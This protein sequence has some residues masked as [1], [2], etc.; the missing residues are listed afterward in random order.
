MRL[1][2]ATIAALGLAACQPAPAPPAKTEAPAETG[3]P[4]AAAESFIPLDGDDE[5]SGFRGPMTVAV[6][7]PTAGAPGAGNGQRYKFVWA[8]GK[9]E[10]VA[11][12]VGAANGAAVIDTLEG[13]KPLT[14]Q[15][16]VR[17]PA[18]AA[19]PLLA[20]EI[21]NV[22]GPEVTPLCGM[23]P[24]THIAI[25][26]AGDLLTLA[27]SVGAFGEPNARGCSN[28]IA[29]KVAPATPAKP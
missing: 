25:Y 29:Y 26:R 19:I 11:V 27:T 14:L 21:E 2:L 12:E 16:A 9:H 23:R 22:S 3:A 24:V 20:V 13:G 10:V 4:I 5:D 18:G 28:T 17:A 7:A 6:S 1:L 8:G 15:T